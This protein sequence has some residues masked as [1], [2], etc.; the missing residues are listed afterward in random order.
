MSGIQYYCAAVAS[1]SSPTAYV[2]TDCLRLYGRLAFTTDTASGQKS[3]NSALLVW[4]RFM[5]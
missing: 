4:R 3:R 5:G 1:C 2:C